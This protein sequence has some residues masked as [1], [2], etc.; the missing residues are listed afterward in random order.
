MPERLFLFGREGGGGK[1]TS[2]D[3]CGVRHF[4]VE[5]QRFLYAGCFRSLP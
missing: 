2:Q 1:K 4:R 3:Y 5:P